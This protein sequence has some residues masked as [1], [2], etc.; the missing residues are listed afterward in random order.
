MAYNYINRSVKKAV[1]KAIPKPRYGKLSLSQAV[2]RKAP[3]V[4]RGC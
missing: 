4:K 3:L 2:Q 1:K